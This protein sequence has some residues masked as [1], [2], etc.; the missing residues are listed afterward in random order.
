M[1]RN[2]IKLVERAL[3]NGFRSKGV[4][5]R[6][7]AEKS[8]YK[9]FIRLY[10]VSDFFRR[11][12]EKDRI[13]EILSVLEENGAKEELPK[14][15]LCVGMTISEYEKEY[16]VGVLRSPFLRAG[17]RKKAGPARKPSPR[18]MKLAVAQARN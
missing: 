16:R 1:A 15:S 11:K 4:K 2:A 18:I 5:V 9:D 3:E 17:A 12:R 6:V 7:F 14:L 13:G 8:D 10:V